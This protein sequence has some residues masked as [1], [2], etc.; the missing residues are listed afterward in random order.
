MT[1]MWLDDSLA[2]DTIILGD[3]TQNEIHSLLRG[4]LF[5]FKKIASFVGGKQAPTKTCA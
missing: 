3:L 5:I 2:S 1:F 4:N